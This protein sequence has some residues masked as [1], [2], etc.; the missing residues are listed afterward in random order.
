MR[1]DFQDQ[2]AALGVDAYEHGGDEV[3]LPAADP[4]P[5][6]VPARLAALLQGGGAVLLEVAVAVGAWMREGSP[7]TGRKTYS[8]TSS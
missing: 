2:H 3:L 4:D 7:S 1:S 8:V 5:Q 6:E